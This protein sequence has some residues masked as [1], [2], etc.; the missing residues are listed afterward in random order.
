MEQTATPLSLLKS[1]FGYESFRPLQAEIIDNVLV[2]RDTLVLMPTGAGKSLCYQLP[3]LLFDGTTLVVSPLIALMKD[4]VDALNAAGIPAAYINSSLSGEEAQ[5]VQAQ[6]R[7][8]AVKL[9]YVAPERLA[10][11]GFQRFLREIELSLIAVDEAHCIS[12]WGHEF[13]PDYR[14][15]RQLHEDFPSTPVIALTATATERVRRDIIDQLALH[16]GETFLSSFNRENLH[17]SVLP[18][19][20]SLGQLT[21]LLDRHRDRPA[22]IYCLSRQETEDIAAGLRAKG[23]EA[24]AYHAGLDSETRRLTQEDFVRDRVPI[25]VATIAF[26]MG[27]DKPDVR[28]VV[29]YSLPK[30]PEGYYQE[31]GR[32]GRDGLP[33]ECVLF[34]SYGDKVRQDYFINRMDD[35]TEQ[36]NAREKIARMVAYAQL[37]TCRRRFLLEYFGESWTGEG[38]GGCDV[39]LEPREEFDAT[40]VAQK[41][42]SAVVRTGERFGTA[43]VV[44]VLIGSKDKRILEMGHDELSVYGIARDRERSELREIISLLQARGLLAQRD[45]DYP[46]LVVTSEGREFLR[47]RG[48]LV[49]SRP[50]QSRGA[51]AKRSVH[52]T[53]DDYDRR[54]F[55]ELR[56][57]RRRLADERNLPPYVVFGDASLRHMATIY[58]RTMEQFAQVRG[59]GAA[60]LQDYGRQF[61]DVISAYASTHGLPERSSHAGSQAPVTR[62]H[63]ATAELVGQGMSVA[64]VARERGLAETTVIGHLER[65]AGQGVLV[66]LTHVLPGS[67]KLSEIEEAF[68]A[69]GGVQLKPVWE[70]L[71]TRVSYDELRLARL[72]LRQ[73]GRLPTGVPS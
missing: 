56:A 62:T 36:Q 38:C 1:R 47:Q 64:E 10:L 48:A 27:I 26:G 2:R 7:Q 49:L 25:V 55:E 22:I 60:R 70:F 40:E 16:Q 71:E 15:L 66:D 57:L 23:Y 69:C 45:G 61:V 35:S 50:I 67:G 58:P 68:N 63:E 18:K 29:H 11:P 9:L 54:L 14:N 52:S 51:R 65:L 42:L 12:E 44:R 17:Y 30:S 6:V 24:R 33:S 43:Y 3:A 21:P 73:E 46:A 72:H 28:L 4:Q 8:G 31:T 20:G 19:E 34:Y 39:C 37:W 41:I 53:D 5:Q 13:R 32:A 59:A